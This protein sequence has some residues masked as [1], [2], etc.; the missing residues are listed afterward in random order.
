MTWRCRDNGGNRL[1]DSLRRPKASPPLPRC[2]PS[3]CRD[4]DGC[5]GSAVGRCVVGCQSG[6]WSESSP[7]R[8]RDVTR[9]MATNDAVSTA[10]A[11]KTATYWMPASCVPIKLFEQRAVKPAGSSRVDY[12]T[13]VFWNLFPSWI[14]WHLPVL[15]TWHTCQKL[16]PPQTRTR[17]K[18]CLKTGAKIEHG[19]FFTENSL[20]YSAIWQV[21]IF[22]DSILTCPGRTSFVLL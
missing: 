19:L 14:S 1:I 7:P 22:I 10:E 13:L 20:Q 16:S 21:S 8:T 18:W 6:M 12:R 4:V 2:G 15:Y 11:S 9:T 5:H 17:K 3:G